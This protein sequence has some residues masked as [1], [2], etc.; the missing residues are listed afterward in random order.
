M[1]N[2]M[3]HGAWYGVDR[4][5]DAIQNGRLYRTLVLPLRYGRVTNAISTSELTWVDLELVYPTIKDPGFSWEHCSRDLV[6]REED[7]DLAPVDLLDLMAIASSPNGEENLR[8][9]DGLPLP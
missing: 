1:G 8:S 9:E 4:N 6:F 3:N 2:A 7:I 5:G